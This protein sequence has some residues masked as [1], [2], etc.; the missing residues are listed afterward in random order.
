MWDDIAPF[1]SKH[2]DVLVFVWTKR[3]GLDTASMTERGESVREEKGESHIKVDGARGSGGSPV[4]FPLQHTVESPGGQQCLRGSAVTTHPVSLL[5]TCFILVLPPLFLAVFSNFQKLNVSVTILPKHTFLL[6]LVLVPASSPLLLKVLLSAKVVTPMTSC[7]PQAAHCRLASLT[8]AAV[9][10]LKAGI[11]QSHS[12][13]CWVGPSWNRLL[14]SRSHNLSLLLRFSLI[15]HTGTVD[16]AS[17]YNHSLVH[18]RSVVLLHNALSPRCNSAPSITQLDAAV[19]SNPKSVRSRLHSKLGFKTER[20]CQVWD[21][22]DERHVWCLGQSWTEHKLV[23]ASRPSAQF[24]RKQAFLTCIGLFIE[25]Q[26]LLNDVRNKMMTTP[27]NLSL[28][29]LPPACLLPWLHFNYILISWW[30]MTKKYSSV[31]CHD[32]HMTNSLILYW[33]KFK[34]NL[35]INVYPVF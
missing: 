30:L 6:S 34:K 9:V 12:H 19:V 23:F 3:N 33:I 5:Q 15:S 32:L 22:Q 16:L 31:S 2:K 17:R 11:I 10:L 35:L 25:K 29:I 4:C 14:R 1:R 20:G 27:F 8:A 7:W 28:F 18:I 26:R 24:W 21:F 13:Y